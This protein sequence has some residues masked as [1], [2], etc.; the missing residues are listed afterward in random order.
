MSILARFR[1]RNVHDVPGQ[2]CNLELLQYV[3]AFLQA[4]PWFQRQ[5][6]RDHLLVASHWASEWHVPRFGNIIK[7]HMIG[8][9]NR[10]YGLL[11]KNHN[12]V[13]LPK[14]YV[15]K[16]VIWWSTRHQTVP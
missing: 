2:G 14:L 5:D 6:G 10:N 8:W 16:H 3:D 4:S 12:R 7:C 15:V 1:N 13:I 11:D 9:G